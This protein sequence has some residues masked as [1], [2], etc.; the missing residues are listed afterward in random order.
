M[1]TTHGHNQGEN[2]RTR[3]A[4]SDSRTRSEAA[5]KEYTDDAISKLEDRVTRQLESFEATVTEANSS[6][7]SAEESARDAFQIANDALEKANEAKGKADEA[8]ESLLDCIL[9]RTE[10]FLELVESLLET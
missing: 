4:H 6:A 8:N 5:A 7:T 3:S 10:V 1:D 2:D 9:L